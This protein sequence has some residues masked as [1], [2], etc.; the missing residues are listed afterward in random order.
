MDST[1]PNSPIQPQPIEIN[2]HIYKVTQ[3]YLLEN[4]DFLN[5]ARDK[6]FA[7]ALLNGMEQSNLL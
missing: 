7:Q 5:K 4:G 1:Q 3:G 2:P 6:D